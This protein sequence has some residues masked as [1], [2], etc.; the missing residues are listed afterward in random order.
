MSTLLNEHLVADSLTALTDWSGDPSGIRRTVALTPDQI[1]ELLAEV[2]VT[3]DSMDHHAEIDRSEG[4]VTFVLSTHSMGGVTELDI[5]LA[6][7]IDD[8]V[9][10]ASGEGVPGEKAPAV[11][12]APTPAGRGAGRTGPGRRQGGRPRGNVDV[13]AEAGRSADEDATS[14][15]GGGDQMEPLMNVPA[16]SGGTV[17]PGLAMP[18]TVPDEPQP[19][20]ARPEGQGAPPAGQNADR[21]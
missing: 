13:V 9:L 2:A 19:G 7:R 5:Y 4:S 3:T 8:L 21:P 18:D 1:E 10:K 17:Q 20:V 11:A 15:T 16:G 12:G 14:D 6:S